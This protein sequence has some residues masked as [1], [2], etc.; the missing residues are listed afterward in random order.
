MASPFALMWQRVRGLSART[1]GLIAV[2]V[3]VAGATAMI[4]LSLRAGAVLRA[5]TE[6]WSSYQVEA[7]SRLLDL[8]ALRTMLGYGGFIHAYKDHVLHGD[9]PTAEMAAA[10]LEAAIVLLETYREQAAPE[11][12]HDIDLVEAVLLDYRANLEVVDE[13]IAAGAP[14][15]QVDRRLS[16]DDAGA[17]SA[18]DRLTERW[19]T[20]ASDARDRMAEASEEG[21]DAAALILWV[22]PLFV[23]GALVSVLMLRALILTS[24]ESARNAAKFRELF[25]GSVNGLAIIGPGLHLFYANPAL[26]RLLGEGSVNELLAKTTLK[27]FLPE[28]EQII[29][30]ELRHDL[31]SGDMNRAMH[32][33]EALRADF[34]EVWLD[35]NAQP[36]DWEGR[37][38][39]QLSIANVTEQVIHERELEFN[40]SEMERQT[41]EL[42]ALAED[43]HA[44]HERAETA[45]REAE[46]RRRFLQ[47]LLATMPS[48]L[49][50]K[51]LNGRIEGCNGA[52]AQL[53]GFNA[54]EDVVGLTVHDLATP[55]EAQRS[56]SLDRALMKSGGTIAYE[57]EVRDREG[58]PHSMIYNKAVF[59]DAA[60]NAAGIVGVITD[61]SDQKR[62]EQELRRL[63][64]TD[65]LT[66]AQN[67]RAF[68]E[69]AD[70]ELSRSS[71][72]DEPLSV[73]LADIDHFK[74]INDTHGHATGD[75]ALKL[76]VSTVQGCLRDTDVLGRM[77]GEEFAV[78]L[79]HTTQSAAVPLADRLRT[80][81]AALEIPCPTGSLHFTV[82]MGVSQAGIHGT[83]VQ[84]L[85][86]AADDALYSAKETGRDRVVAA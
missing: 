34:S 41:T 47:A 11:E 17:L 58:I 5:T 51:D 71:R 8:G 69:A 4:A 63:A 24:R 60:G 57:R 10:Q 27:P 70:R 33:M 23:V 59:T 22:L 73:L 31:I 49:F 75:E 67:R 54:E 26:A 29:L 13:A 80:R 14:P 39:V 32:R 53:Y 74:R 30:E 6:T 20:V 72:Y 25:D 52:F 81:L 68:L 18:L 65:P 85:L 3:T 7:E 36:I 62:M 1:L 61:I 43:L 48:P 9:T 45:L 40:R 46:E 86:Q 19:R 84:A 15:D 50:Y 37:Q 12:L 2:V 82:S 55:E 38:A 42:V 21:H 64:T 77:G 16:A 78:L 44:E 76:F 56:D 66:G 79:P 28:H 83:S 35:L